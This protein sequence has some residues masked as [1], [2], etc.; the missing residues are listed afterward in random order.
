MSNKNHKEYVVEYDSRKFTAEQQIK[1][2]INSQV[3]R[4]VNNELMSR[5]KDRDPSLF[6]T[7]KKGLRA[8]Y[9]RAANAEYLAALAAKDAGDQS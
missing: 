7:L 4:V 2:R 8:K 1:N 6:E 9:E 5:M 3:T